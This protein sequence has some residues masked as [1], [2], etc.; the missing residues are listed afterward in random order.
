LKTVAQ[1]EIYGFI[2]TTVTWKYTRGII[3]YLKYH[4]N[5]L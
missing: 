4:E 5:P 1:A 3:L 2:Y